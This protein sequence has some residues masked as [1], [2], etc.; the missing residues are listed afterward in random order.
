VRAPAE[1]KFPGI[2]DE[3]PETDDEDEFKRDFI[4]LAS[5]TT[6]IIDTRPR[7]YDNKEEVPHVVYDILRSTAISVSDFPKRKTTAEYNRLME[8]NGV[9]FYK[10]GPVTNIR[11]EK[12]LIPQDFDLPENLFHARVN[13]ICRK[14]AGSN[15][16]YYASRIKSSLFDSTPSVSEI[17]V[18][19]WWEQA[20]YEDKISILTVKGKGNE[21]TVTER[22][23]EYLD[24]LH[25]FLG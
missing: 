21:I 1:Q 25:C 11:P 10:R 6:A 14:T 17:G 3:Q 5:S 24:H 13:S 9:K 4:P 8:L 12:S 20:S 23:I 18:T 7:Y 16:G 2:I 22:V 15:P 19:G